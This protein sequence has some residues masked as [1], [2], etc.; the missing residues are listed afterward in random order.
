VIGIEARG[1][2][3]LRLDDRHLELRRFG[4]ED[5]GNGGPACSAPDDDNLTATFGNRGFGKKCG[6]RR[7]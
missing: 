2:D 4:L 7:N 3:R 6:G 1:V 5:A